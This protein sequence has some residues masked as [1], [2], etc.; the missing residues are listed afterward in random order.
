MSAFILSIIK[1]LAIDVVLKLVYEVVL[2]MLGRINWKI[3]IERF[4]SRL[5]SW[6][7]ERLAN[8]K[9]NSLGKD[10]A[11]DILRQMQDEGL[12]KAK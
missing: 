12:P 9:T 8:M 2:M 4:V 7:I 3:V 1:K 5:V 10:T 11:I 6:G